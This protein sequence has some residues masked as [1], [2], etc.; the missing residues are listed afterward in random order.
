MTEDLSP[1]CIE[2]IGFTLDVDSTATKSDECVLSLD[3][4]G[5]MV[6]THM[7]PKHMNST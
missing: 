5:C 2:N 6:I 1:G 7:M 3:G 4:E